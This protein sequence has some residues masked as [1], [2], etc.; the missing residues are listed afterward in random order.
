VPEFLGLIERRS[1]RTPDLFD[2]QRRQV[3]R[4]PVFAS[5]RRHHFL[6]KLRVA[7]KLDEEA[8]PERWNEMLA[9]MRFVLSIRTGTDATALGLEP[10][11][12]NLVDPKS[13]EAMARA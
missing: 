13:R 9:D 8:V 12:Q 11:Q 1:Q 6:D 5:P 10:A 3:A 4:A 2:K 7:L